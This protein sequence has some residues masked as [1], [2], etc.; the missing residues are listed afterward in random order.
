MN[1]DWPQTVEVGGRAYTLHP[2]M[3]MNEYI[4]CVNALQN[5][6]ESV[7]E[8]GEALGLIRHGSPAG[9]GRRGE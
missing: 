7:R 6:A 2:E 9:G 3:E 1:A 5:E 8:L 4:D